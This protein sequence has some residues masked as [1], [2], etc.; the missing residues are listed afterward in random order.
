MRSETA[1]DEVVGRLLAVVGAAE[2]N[3]GWATV[4]LDRAR[5][6]VAGGTEPPEVLARD[7]H[8]GAHVRRVTARTGEPLFLLEPDTE[9]RLAA[10]LARHGEGP[11]VTYVVAGP[12][13]PAR[14]V[15]A[16]FALSTAEAGPLGR[17]RLVLGGPRFGPHVVLVERGDG[18]RED[19]PPAGTI[20]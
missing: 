6:D 16:G 20:D 8:L 15:A 5:G 17:Q 4:E 11:H 13:A 2:T 1:S 14:A 18:G 9:G 19:A 12:D 3:V 7:P 10:T